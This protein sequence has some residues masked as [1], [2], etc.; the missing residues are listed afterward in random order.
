MSHLSHRQLKPLTDL[1]LTGVGG[2]DV[3]YLGY[4]EVNL[5]PVAKDAGTKKRVKT[6][7]LILADCRS[8]QETP[9]LIRTNTRLLRTLLRDYRKLGG[10]RLKVSK[11]WAAAYR[12]AAS[13]MR[14]GKDGCLGPLRLV[15]PVELPA[16]ET[17]EVKVNEGGSPEPFS[18][19]E[20]P[21]SEGWRHRIEQV[22]REHRD[23]FST[24]D[25]DI[26]RTAEVMHRI[27]LTDDTPFR[28]K[29][30]RIPPADF[31]D[32]KEHIEELLRK[33]IIRESFSPYAS[34]IVLVRKKNGD[35]RLTVDYRLLN[36]R[37]VKDQYNIP[38]IEDT[39]HSLS[40]AVWFSSLDLK[41]GYYQIE[42]EEE[43]KQKTAFWCPLGF[44]EFNRMPQGICNAPA[45]FQRLM[46]K[47]MG[48]MAFQDVIVYLDDLLIFSHTLEEHETKLRKVLA[49]LREYGLKLNPDKCQFLRPSVKCLGHV[50]SADGVQTDPDK[51]SAVSTWPRP[52]NVTELKSFLGFA[53]YYRRFI[54]NYSRIAKPLNSLSQ[55]YEP[56]RKRRG[57]ARIR[58]KDSPAQRPSPD[59]P[60]GD[61][62]T[63]VCQ[64]AFDQLIKK[65]TMAPIL[66]FANFEEPFVLHTDAS[67][68]GLGAALYQQHEGKLRPVAYAA[69]PIQKRGQLPAHKLEFL[70]LKWAVTA[71]FSDYLYGNKF[72]VMTD[73][74]PLTYVLSTVKLDAVGHRWL[75]ALANYEFD[76]K[77]KPGRYNQDADGL[78]RRPHEPPA[79][80]EE[81]RSFQSRTSEMRERLLGSPT[82]LSSTAEV[83][84]LHCRSQM[85]LVRAEVVAAL[86]RAQ[87][88]GRV[89]CRM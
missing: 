32:A 85:T 24:D 11:H 56:V 42:M 16:G 62:W 65:L 35:I 38:K 18:L 36:S 5:T 20:S 80:D 14:Y 87:P 59:T 30:R 72:L 70:A 75:A 52:Q 89:N 76:L 71:K 31:K 41:S 48:A 21:V 58:T 86:C 37:T 9:L 78:S 15:H 39:F 82:Q 34:A 55:L 73:N 26:G 17:T 25:L 88:S 43:D 10:K 54:E 22:L 44:Y 33:S 68:S 84:R 46:E 49:R 8:R 83:N 79:E 28:Q 81:Y 60:F 2:Y 4:I 64:T 6:L 47:C 27:R 67:T 40:G 66:N 1:D 50:I 57:K 45:T 61:S 12:L 53:G 77:Y 19:K 63:S 23:V 51:I 69:G 7:A 74:N 13:E 3:P 29:S